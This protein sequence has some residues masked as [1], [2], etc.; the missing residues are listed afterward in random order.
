MRYKII[1][2]FFFI[3]IVS[4]SNGQ[5]INRF[6]DKG[7]RQGYWELPSAMTRIKN[8]KKIKGIEA[9]QYGYFFDNK[10]QGC[11]D[12]KDTHGRLVGHRWYKNDTTIVEI[13][14]LR[15][16]VSSIIHFSTKYEY[17]ENPDLADFV[18]VYQ[19][20]ISFNRRG[21]IKQRSFRNEE[22]KMETI[23]Y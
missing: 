15:G 11:W 1:G 2:V 19:E 21:K 9:K 3:F 7:L 14:Y 20:V 4:V 8:E 23:K 22:G 18:Y 10:K 6:D 17:T 13:Q 5:E 12:I 16:K